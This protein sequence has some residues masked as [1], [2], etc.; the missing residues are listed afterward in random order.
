MKKLLTIMAAAVAATVFGGYG[1]LPDTFNASTGY[2]ILNTK[3]AAGAE[4]SGGFSSFYV[5]DHWSD[6][7]APHSNTNY[8]VPSGY[9]F[10]T[11]RGPDSIV[12][13][14]AED[15]TCLTFKG[16]IVVAAGE[17]RGQSSGYECTIPDLRMLPGSSFYWGAAW[18]TLRGDMTVYGTEAS[19]VRFDYYLSGDGFRQEVA[20]NVKGDASSWLSVRAP[21]H[22]NRTD[23][24]KLAYVGHIALTGDLSEFFGTLKI[25]DYLA[26]GATGHA[27]YFGY[28]FANSSVSNAAVV[29]GNQGSIY[30][31]APEGVEVR[32]LSINGADTMIRIL[33]SDNWSH[34]VPRFT[35][36]E[37]IALN[38]HR[39]SLA[40]CSYSITS[41]P[42]Y[43][44]AHI[45]P[46]PAEDAALIRLTPSAVA[47]GLSGDPY[48]SFA[49]G[50]A[51]T[52]AKTEWLPDPDGGMTLWRPAYVMCQ[53]TDQ[54]G[55]SCLT[56]ALTQ[57]GNN[58]WSDGRNPADD[59]DRASKRYFSNVVALHVPK[60]AA[61]AP[62]AFGGGALVLCSP[63]S[64]N[65]YNGGY[66][67]YC[68]ELVLKGA[69]FMMCNADVT[70]D[71]RKD[72]EDGGYYTIYR[73]QGE[74]LVVP[75]PY[76][77]TFKVWGVRKLMRIE[78]EVVGG[79][80]IKC[81]TY[82]ASD[83]NNDRSFY[84]FTALNTNFT[85]KINVSMPYE[86]TKYAASGVTVPNWKQRTRLFVYDERNLGGERNTFAYDALYL[87]HYA[88]LFPLNDV[89]FTDGWNRG[90]AI[91]DIGRMNVQSGLTLSILRPLNVNGNLVKDG[92]GTLALGGTLTF[93]GATQSATPTANKNLLTVRGGSIKP[94]SAHA[95]DGFA[96]TFTNNASIRLD[97]NT[98]STELMNYVIVNVKETAAPFALAANQSVVPVTVT[99]PENGTKFYSIAVCTVTDAVAANLPEEKFDVR[100]TSNRRA[101]KFEKRSNG[102]GTVT[103]VAQFGRGLVITYR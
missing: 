80:T 52:N 23:K 25:D 67:F 29:V 54:Q 76:D 74:K 35:V 21:R 18:P 20:Q 70:T 31:T 51:D 103:Y 101:P 46:D 48:E 38:G 4:S 90:I 58:H 39:V 99:P 75:A 1:D 69:T 47:G 73:I 79:G 72:D 19:P 34:D 82:A 88:E 32:S 92:A 30:L 15:P 61:N 22:G 2:V 98:E 26:S 56:N 60:A 93:N 7:Q 102:D 57:G 24:P 40:L 83:Y 66:G 37:A 78:S 3:D 55:R 49:F 42:R 8:Y 45:N 36:R 65:M 16:D 28:E 84:E 63:C 94:L 10:V 87:D 9:M 27:G 71:R 62:F 6:G 95:F 85:G 11:P 77:N 12:A 89:T 96:I 13:K 81:S 43:D 86:T 41:A 91:G 44:F 5:G 33:N 64:F 53:Y 68:K 50:I 100:N 14:L 59:P 97:A 17:V